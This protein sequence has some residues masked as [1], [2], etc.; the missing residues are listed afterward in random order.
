MTIVIFGELIMDKIEV[1]KI[2]NTHG[3]KGDVKVVSW[4][5]YPEVFEDFS[6]VFDGDTAYEIEN[7]KYH[8][9]SVILKL[10]G[11]DSIDS[12]EKMRNKIITALRSEFNLPEGKFFIA[13]IIGLTVVSKGD[14]IGIIS[15][16]IQTGAN[17]VY[18]IKRKGAKDLLF[19]ATP[20]TVISTDINTGVVD[21]IIPKGL[22]EI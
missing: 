15:D 20:E 2:V 6:K 17:D 18:V 21:V 9:G 12:A 7:V 1:G 11:C 8:K 22:D 16:V 4:C 19:P 10:S 3:L 5:D 13:D 14:N